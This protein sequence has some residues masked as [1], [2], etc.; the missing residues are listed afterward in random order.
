MYHV[1]TVS[2][3]RRLDRT[4]AAVEY[5]VHPAAPVGVVLGY[6]HD[7]LA[8]DSAGRDAA[9]SYSAGVYYDVTPRT[10]LRAAASRRIRFPTVSQLYDPTGGNPALSSERATEYDAGIEQELAA[11]SRASL[12]VFHTDVYGYIERPAPGQPFANYS[13]YRFRG[14]ELTAETAA[15]ARLLLRGGYTFLDTHDRSPGAQFQALQ[16]RPRHKATLEARY[17]LPGGPA[18][19]A[20]IMRVN[21]QVYFSRT[22]PRREANLAGYTLVKVRLTQA[23]WER[24]ATLYVGADNLLNEAYQEEYGYPQASRA[25]YAGAAV[26]W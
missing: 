22:T 15:F 13:A 19:V 8:K 17:A 25:V 12:S 24:A 7:W 20:S 9:P 11:G 21:G 26:H 1:R 2:D 23:F 16:Y 10:R 3:P 5:E 14:A 18:V 6:A 4:G